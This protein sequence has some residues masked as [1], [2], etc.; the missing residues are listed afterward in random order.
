M[1]YNK[2]LCILIA[3]F[4]TC[5]FA[6]DDGY[7]KTRE[8][9]RADEMGSMVGSEGIVFRPGKV[10][11][12]STKTPDSK[13]NKFLWQASLE[14]LDMAPLVILDNKTGVIATDWYSDKANPNRTMK[15]VVNITDNIIAPE[16]IDV[17]IQEKVL[18]SGR[19]LD[20]NLDR[21]MKMSIE[22]KILRR[23]KELYINAAK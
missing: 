10:R 21:A 23:A 7:P 2:I 4:A 14:V 15:V 9:R 13:I 11:N 17:K 8:E 22:T 18:K 1:K 20:E 5:A 19:W 6:E 16:S 12:E 3:C